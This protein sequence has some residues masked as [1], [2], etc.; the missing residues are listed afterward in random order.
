M[1]DVSIYIILIC[2]IYTENVCLEH[3]HLISKGS[4]L[5]QGCSSDFAGTYCSGDY[6]FERSGV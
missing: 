1:L 4:A 3:P 2:T 5:L 6:M